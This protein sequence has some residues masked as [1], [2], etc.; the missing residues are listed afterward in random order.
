M[1]YK[2]LPLLVLFIV[3]LSVVTGCRTQRG[4]RT[5]TNAFGLYERQTASYE[6]VPNTTIPI[7][8]SDFDPGADYSGNR[9]SLLWGLITYYDY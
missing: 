5:Y 3:L 8:R 9:V 2:K 6:Y 4:D 7:R 1:K